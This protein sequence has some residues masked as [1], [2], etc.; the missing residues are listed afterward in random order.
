[1]GDVMLKNLLVKNDYTIHYPELVDK[2]GDFTYCGEEFKVCE[3]KLQLEDV[4]DEESNYI[5]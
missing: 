4:D 1:M 2:D 3:K 5:E